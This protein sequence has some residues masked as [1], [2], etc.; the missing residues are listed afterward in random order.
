M[1]EQGIYIEVY[2]VTEQDIYVEVHY[3]TDRIFCDTQKQ[4]AGRL[5]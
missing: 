3:V 2:F 1:T 4:K 5:Q